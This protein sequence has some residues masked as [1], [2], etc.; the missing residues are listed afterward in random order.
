VVDLE[1]PPAAVKTETLPLVFDG[2]TA[3]VSITDRGDL[4]DVVMPFSRE[5]R[6]TRGARFERNPDSKR[7]FKMVYLPGDTGW[8][9][10]EVRRCKG[11][12]GG[13]T[14]R[15]EVRID[16]QGVPLPSGGSAGWDSV[17]VGSWRNTVMLAANI[18]GAITW[19]GWSV[20]DAWVGERVVP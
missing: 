14:S 4:L 7:L 2:A 10:L 18:Y 9:A 16:V 20:A 3:T 11:I 15:W 6:A 1:P 5:L 8:A 17:Q 12:R 13:N 19:H